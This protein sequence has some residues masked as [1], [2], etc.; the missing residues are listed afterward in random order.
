MR[1]ETTLIL[2]PAV[3]TLHLERDFTWQYALVFGALIAATDPIAVV[4]VF[5]SLGVPRRLSMLLDGESLLNDGTAIVFFTLS[6]SLVTGASVTGWR[7]TTDF[8]KIVGFGG[9]IGAAVGLAVSQVISILAHGM[10]VSPLLRWLG[11]VQGREHREAYEFARG[12]L[13]A[14]STALEELERTQPGGP[15]EV[16]GGHRRA[17]VEGR[18]GRRGKNLRPAEPGQDRG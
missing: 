4:A 3:N 11:I 10:T 7:L 17:P 16:A 2:A 8:F 18:I 6:L 15:R 9:L 1:N 12:K 13:Q 14:A 5:K